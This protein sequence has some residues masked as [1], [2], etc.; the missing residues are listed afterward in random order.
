M[1]TYV[2]AGGACAAL[3]VAVTLLG[4][5]TRSTDGSVAMTTEPGPPLTSAPSQSD[6][7]PPPP[8]DALSM[9]CEEYNDLDEATQLAVVREILAQE[10]NPLG[11]L[12]AQ[13]EEIAK[14]LADAVCQFLPSSTVNEVLL[15]GG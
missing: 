2:R 7:V 6:G 13:N 9:S 14:A 4:G 5:C 15:G 12:G 8:A 1:T 11:P 10:T 3:L